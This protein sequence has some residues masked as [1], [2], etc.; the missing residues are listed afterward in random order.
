MD[1]NEASVPP[2]TVEPEPS[3]GST[4]AEP[5]ATGRHGLVAR[6]GLERYAVL[7]VLAAVIIGFSIGL[8]ATFAQSS[9]FTAIA[10]AGVVSLILAIGLT[11]PLR[12]GDFDLSVG[13]NM[14]MCAV[15]YAELTTN[16]HMNWFVVLV[17]VLLIGTFVGVVNGVLVVV[18][19]L[20]GFIAT[21]GT[22][23]VLGGLALGITSSTTVIGVPHQIL[24]LVRTQVGGL[25]TGV[26]IGWGIAL[27]VWYVYGYTPWGRNL[28][29]I[30]G[31]RNAA[32]LSGISVSRARIFAFVICGLLAAVA[33]IILVGQLG[34]ADPT[35]G[36]EYLLPP[37]AAAF[38][39]TTVIQMRRFNVVGTVI[40]LYLLSTVVTG[41]QLLGAPSW[42]ADVFNGLA[43]VVAVA[44]ARLIGRGQRS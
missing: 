31:N 18:V 36:P 43:L 2:A 25:Q 15:I 23:T 33:G 4:A 14:A 44:F 42:I 27:V 24:T 40:G 35:V 19:G 21:L 8:P 29:F 22:M 37:Y 17:L 32:R 26:F 28:L 39:G 10:S 6:L 5:A 1:R 41:L 30:G 7:I 9:N 3:P 16:H 34:A 38:L 12:T 20:D 11:F 13:A